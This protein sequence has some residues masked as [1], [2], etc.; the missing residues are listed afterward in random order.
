MRIVLYCVRYCVE[1]IS[2]LAQVRS[3]ASRLLATTGCPV[4]FVRFAVYRRSHCC[5]DR[6]SPTM[7]SDGIR[8][9]APPDSCPFPFLPGCW[10]LNSAGFLVRCTPISVAADMVST[11]W[12][13]LCP[14]PRS[15]LRCIACAGEITGSASDD[16]RSSDD[17]PRPR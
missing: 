8:E 4:V 17:L 11:A 1:L 9:T 2:T 14:I 6:P 15:F 5:L 3:V 7:P 16:D 13:F 10:R 12:R